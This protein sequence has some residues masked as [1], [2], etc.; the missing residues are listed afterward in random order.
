MVGICVGVLLLPWHSAPFR[1]GV[2]S[3]GKYALLLGVIGLALYVLAA[4]RHLDVRWWQLASLPLALGCLAL[5]AHALNR[6]PAL[7]AIISAVS[8]IAWLVVSRRPGV[9]HSLS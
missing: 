9:A 2:L 5:S 8:A 7:G 3:E 4:T 1:S 6:H